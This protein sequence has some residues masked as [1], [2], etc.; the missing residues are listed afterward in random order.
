MWRT[1]FFVILDN[2]LLFYPPNN[3]K[4]QTLKKRRKAWI[5]YHFTHVYHRWKPYD[6]WLLRYGVWRI[7]FFIILDNFLPFYPL[8][9]WKIKILKKRK[10]HLEILSFYTSVPKIMIILYYTVPDIWC[11]TDVIVIFHFG[12]FFTLLPPMHPPLTAQK[13]KIFKKWK[14][15]QEISSFYTC[16]PKIMNRWCTFPEIWCAT[17]RGTDRWMDRQMEKVTHRGGC[18]T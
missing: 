17:D 18:P 14:K 10:K 9:T 12:L 13:I 15:H 2:F 6:A 1:Q 5:Y 4:T 3:P 16:V 8:K 7:E 11:M